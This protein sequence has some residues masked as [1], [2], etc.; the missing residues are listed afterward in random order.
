MGNDWWG[1]VG[2]GGLEASFLREGTRF[3]HS[4]GL[5]QNYPCRA[6]VQNRSFC[7]SSLTPSLEGL[8]LYWP[9]RHNRKREWSSS[10]RVSKLLCT[11]GNEKWE[12]SQKGK[13]AARQAERGG[14]WGKLRPL[15]GSSAEGGLWSQAELSHEDLLLCCL[16]R[17][18][19]ELPP[20]CFLK[21]LSWVYTVHSC[22]SVARFFLVN[23]TKGGVQAGVGNT[24]VW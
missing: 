14:S 2:W 9:P 21:K 6:K 3:G 7:R 22:S 5:C 4:T 1:M 23:S 19:S 17:L 20:L 16:C 12:R 24:K 10:C 18:R 15:V 8:L 13:P 11:T